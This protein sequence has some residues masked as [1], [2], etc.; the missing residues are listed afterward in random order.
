MHPAEGL[1]SPTPTGIWNPGHK[2]P[3]TPMLV[4]LKGYRSRLQG[5][6][7]FMAAVLLLLF[8]S[9]LKPLPGIIYYI[10]FLC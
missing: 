9:L 4:H 6:H 7:V 1:L 10:L 3:A 2:N 8:L 5:Q